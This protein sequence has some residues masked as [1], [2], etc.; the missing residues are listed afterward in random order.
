MTDLT[1]EDYMVL[2]CAALCTEDP[3]VILKSRYEKLRRLGL[4]REGE[5]ISDFH[6]VARATKKGRDVALEYVQ[7]RCQE[8]S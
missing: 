5:E 6:V 8:E 2:I 1:H 3:P 7:E 4:I